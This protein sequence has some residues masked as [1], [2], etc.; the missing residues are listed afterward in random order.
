MQ[1]DVRWLDSSASTNA[2]LASAARDGASAGAV[3]AT[4]N[5]SAGRGRLDRRWEAP[6]G[7]GIAVSV[8]L[9]PDVL[10]PS[11]WGWISLATGVALVDAVNGFGLQA[12]LK[13]PND[14]EV[15][16]RKIAGILVERVETNDGPAAIVGFGLNTAMTSDQLPVPTA[17]SLHLHG[18]DVSKEDALAAALRALASVLPLVSDDANA[19]RDRY[20]G[21]CSTIGAT[22]RVE[23]PGDEM[24]DGLATD[25]D[26]QGRLV[27]DGRAIS[28]G[29][30]VHVRR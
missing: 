30:V 14:V 4:E 19:L 12:A 5:Q 6:V 2:D 16:G 11:R 22:V 27:V 26:E 1:W 18:V 9:R 23:L 25:V 21:A 28:A 3:L 29:D 7:S 20:R 13:W 24:L 17:T 10:P 8:L 15:D